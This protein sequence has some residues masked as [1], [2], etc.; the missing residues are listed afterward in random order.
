MRSN[1]RFWEAPSFPRHHPVFAG[2]TSCNPCQ[3][4]TLLSHGEDRATGKSSF[5]VTD[6]EV[7]VEFVSPDQGRR[8]VRTSP[9]KQVAAPILH[10]MR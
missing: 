9:V 7:Q 8:A 3:R 4:I 1:G 2:L 10:C 6:D 5:I